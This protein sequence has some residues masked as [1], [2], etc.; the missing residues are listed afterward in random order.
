MTAYT[1]IYLLKIEIKI[2]RRNNDICF[3]KA[4]NSGGF[5]LFIHLKT[6]SMYAWIIYIKQR[7]ITVIVF[8][9]ITG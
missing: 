1:S 6:D 7:R 9:I 5:Y 2:N 3:L 4:Q 8:L